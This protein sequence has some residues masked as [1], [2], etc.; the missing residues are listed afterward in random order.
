MAMRIGEREIG[1]RSLGEPLVAAALDRERPLPS[2]IVATPGRFFVNVTSSGCGSSCAYCYVDGFRQGQV[3]LTPDDLEE[4]LRLMTAHPGF[5]AG[6]RGTLV[7]MCPDTEPFKTSVSTALVAQVLSRVLPIGN[8]LQLSTKE[9]VPPAILELIRE[10]RRFAG[11]VI[12]FTSSST[13]SK[14]ATVEPSASPPAARF[15]NFEAC[16][17]YGIT[18]C[19]YV[20]PFLPAT[21]ADLELYVDVARNYRPST[22]CVGVLYKPSRAG[23]AANSPRPGSKFHHPVHTELEAPALETSV[24]EFRARLAQVLEGPVF[25]SSVCVSAHAR[26]WYPSPHIW[27]EL[28]DLCVRCRDCEGDLRLRQDPVGTT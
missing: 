23:E 8:P 6:P 2:N 11:Q 24:I 25:H 15:T 22:A 3:A 28:P 9:P 7:S 27:R 1:H 14:A 20:K 18:S 10:R 26:G 19:L 16:R 5:A 4:S 17:L 21:Y 12:L 13:I